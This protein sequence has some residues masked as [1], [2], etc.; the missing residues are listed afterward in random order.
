MA[1]ALGAARAELAAARG[2][3]AT[4]PAKV[5]LGGV[6]PDAV[7]VDDERRG[8]TTPCAWATWDAEHALA[9][10]LGAHHARAEDEARSPVGEAFATSADLEVVGDELHVRLE[11]L[12]APRRSPAIAAVCAELN[13]AE[14]RLSRHPPTPRRQRQGPWER[15][16]ATDDGP[17]PAAIPPVSGLD[18]AAGYRSGV[19]APPANRGASAQG[20]A[21]SDQATALGRRSSTWKA[22]QHRSWHP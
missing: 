7:R 21:D 16:S 6:R 14:T 4:I 11:T 10:A 22:G 2:Q 5:P 12:P 9:R 17:N 8:L 1:K 20:A 15:P 18:F 3:S 19:P 13:E